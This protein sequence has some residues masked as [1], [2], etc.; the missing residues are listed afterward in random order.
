MAITSYRMP[1]KFPLLLLLIFGLQIVLTNCSYANPSK[2]ITL[3]SKDIMDDISDTESLG[4]NKQLAQID[5]VA[6]KNEYEPFTFSA[7]CKNGCNSV[8]VAITD[9]QKENGLEKIVSKTLEIHQLMKKKASY[10]INDWILEPIQKQGIYIEKGKSVRFWVTIHIPEKASPGL[11]SGTLAVKGDG[12]TPVKVPISLRVLDQ[13][14]EDPPDVHFALL[15]T[16]SPFGQR[17]YPERYIR[18][19]QKVLDFYRELRSHG[20][21]CVSPK[22]SDWPYRKGNIE[23]LKAEISLATKAGLR[24]PVLWYMSA[25]INGAKGGTA[26]AHYDGKCDNWNETR[27]LSNLREIV[28]VAKMAEKKND[29][30]E[31]IFITVDE[32]GTDTEDQKI[33][34]LRMDI[35]KKSLKVVTDMGARGATT[36]TEL[37]DNRHNKPPF[38]KTPNELREFWDRVRRYCQIRIYGYGYPQGETNLYAEKKDAHQRGHELWFYNNKAIMKTDRNLARTYFG[39]WGWKVGAQGLTAWT[40]PGARTVQWEIVREGIDD[41]KYLRIIETLLQT[42]DISPQKRNKARDFL[43]RVSKSVKLDR[44]GF[45]KRWKPAMDPRLFRKNAAAIIETLTA[46]G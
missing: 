44:N 19:E 18:L 15:Y 23:G 46:G 45:A 43:S 10:N 39:L 9:L 36:V 28:A 20:M 40:Y 33:N 24:G 30:P 6:L 31:V 42:R 26:Y 27:D 41:F 29:F 38:S 21:T 35:L 5:L 7:Y 34:H 12:E 37:V 16:T 2:E 17:Y 11:Y 25:L 22:C 8:S 13:K 14:L 4:W 3:V 1:C 32:P